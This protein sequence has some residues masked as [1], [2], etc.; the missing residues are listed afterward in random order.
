MAVPKLGKFAKNTAKKRRQ[1]RLRLARVASSSGGHGNITKQNLARNIARF[2]TGQFMFFREQYNTTIPSISGVN[3]SFG[4]TFYGTC[5]NVPVSWIQT[6]DATTSATDTQLPT[7]T[8]TWRE[9]HAVIGSL[10]LTVPT[11]VHVFMIK[12]TPAGQ[13]YFGANAFSGSLFNLNETHTGAFGNVS[14]NPEFFYILHQKRFTLGKETAGSS[15]FPQ[16]TMTIVERQRLYT[17][18]CNPKVSYKDPIRGWTNLTENEVPRHNRTYILMAATS[19]YNTE[20]ALNAVNVTWQCIH[21]VV[22]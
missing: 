21:K 1:S 5:I 13:S 9:F 2:G 11:I 15:G 12:M 6:Y 18:K 4:P 8:E 16:D 3:S 17:H 14:L 20:T 10:N 22:H 19:L 7:V